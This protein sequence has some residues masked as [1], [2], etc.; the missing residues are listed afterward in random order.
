MVNA[1]GIVVVLFTGGGAFSLFGFLEN[2]FSNVDDTLDKKPIDIFADFLGDILL[3]F[4]KNASVRVSESRINFIVDQKEKV[5]IISS[6]RHFVT[7]I[8]ESSC[9]SS[10]RTRASSSRRAQM[11]RSFSLR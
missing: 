7:Q 10:D 1:R 4:Q 8:R 11:R 3:L 5:D 6:F 2:T 9:A